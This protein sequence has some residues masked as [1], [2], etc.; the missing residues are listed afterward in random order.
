MIDCEWLMRGVRC[1][2]RVF[3]WNPWRVKF[4]S[5]WD[6]ESCCGAD[7]GQEAGFAHVGVETALVEVVGM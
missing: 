1:Y 3:G 6:D 7:L 4:P 2:S 5:T